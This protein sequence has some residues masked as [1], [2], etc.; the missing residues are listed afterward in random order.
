M[1]VSAQ[2]VDV[3][4]FQS[5]VTAAELKAAGLSFAFCKATNGSEGADPGFA[6]NWATITEAGIWRGAYHELTTESAAAQAQ[7]FIAVVRAAGVRPGDMF[8]VVAS[9][10]SGVTGAEVSTFACAV[11]AA[12]PD[13]PTLVYADLSVLPQ[14]GEL[15][16]VYPLWIAFYSD[17]A[18]VSVAPWKGWTFWQWQAGGGADGGDR[19]AF[20]GTKADLSAFIAS[21]ILPA[22]AGEWTFGPVRSL[23]APSIGPHSVRLT[24]DAPDFFVNTPPSPAPGIEEYEITV[25]LAGGSTVQ[26]SKT[27]GKAPN[28]QSCQVNGLKP[29]TRYDAR[30]RVYD[31]KHAGPW[32][33]VSFTTPAV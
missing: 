14:L 30:V 27:V 18:P 26:A 28:P 10:Y 16:T 2:G 15:C 8:A 1:T 25:T 11:R 17:S 5:P 23:D 24:W 9:D 33:T 19:N 4:A 12:F 20:N 13:G 7:H 22:P 31:T 29:G 3:S 21:Y 6:A 32:G